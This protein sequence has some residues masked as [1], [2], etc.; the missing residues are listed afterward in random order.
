[1]NNLDYIEILNIDIK[2]LKKNKNYSIEIVNKDNSEF[3]DK[4]NKEFK[5]LE[6]IKNYENLLKYEE[7]INLNDSLIQEYIVQK[8]KDIKE[9][10]NY[11]IDKDNEINIYK[12]QFNKLFNSENNT[13]NDIPTIE[14]INKLENISNENISN[15]NTD[16][17][18]LI[19]NINTNGLIN[20]IKTY[21]DGDYV[22][23]KL[24]NDSQ[25]STEINNIELQY[26]NINSI[27]E[28]NKNNNDISHIEIN[29]YIGKNIINGVYNCG[30]YIALKSN[31]SE[32]SEI[33][34]FE[35]I[36]IN[37]KPV[38]FISNVAKNIIKINYTIRI[39]LF[40]LKTNF[41]N[42]KYDNNENYISII[43]KFYNKLIADDNTYSEDISYHEKKL[44]EIK[45]KKN[46]L[47]HDMKEF[48]NILSINNNANIDNTQSDNANIID[49]ITQSDNNLLSDDP[50]IIAEGT[51]QT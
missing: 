1:M 16:T 2:I 48:E 15:D 38:I 11:I 29:N 51:S 30:I 20:T 27:I 45:A 41:I 43:N 26:K 49:N 46:A 21:L 50:V 5:L 13:I 14:D 22:I 40:L 9:V 34:D 28:I 19:D 25:M 32:D 42:S 3:L 31:Y 8:K 33:K 6:I 39:L 23:N 4:L 35:I 12:M 37:N 36:F 10:T 47:I 18:N 7:V 17:N 44:E 24:I